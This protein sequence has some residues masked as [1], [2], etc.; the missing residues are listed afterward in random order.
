MYMPI[1]PAPR[2]YA[3]G[4]K[5]SIEVAGTDKAG[6]LLHR[7][8]HQISASATSTSISSSSSSAPAV[9]PVLPPKR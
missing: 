1:N 7:C 5:V 2:S 8:A 3:Q 9:S 4:L 6:S